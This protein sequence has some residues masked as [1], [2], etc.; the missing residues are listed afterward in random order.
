MKVN[1]I[2]RI[3]RVFEE[4]DLHSNDHNKR[5][6]LYYDHFYT[7]EKHL[8]FKKI[9]G[10]KG[11]SFEELKILEIGAGLG[12]NMLFFKSLGFA[13][14]N[15]YANELTE[16]RFKKLKTNLPTANLYLGDAQTLPFENTFDVV[17]Q[18]TVFTSILD[19]NLKKTLAQKMLSYTKKSGVILWYDFQYD[20]PKNKNVK[21]IKKREIQQLFHDA[22]SIKFYHVTLAPPIGRR[23]GRHYNLINF[24]CPF[25]RTHLIAAIVK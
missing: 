9:L 10:Y 24:L 7:C 21:G 14:H 4:R 1:E 11:K 8:H 3:R 16:G 13:W 18:S 25:L 19:P 12:G 15:I 20:N 22:A 17:L 2:E 5:D 23:I 6:G